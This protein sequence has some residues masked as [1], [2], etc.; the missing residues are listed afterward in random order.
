MNKLQKA[1]DKLGVVLET[2]INDYMLTPTE[3]NKIK[4]QYKTIQ[5]L[6]NQQSNSTFKEC[7]KEWEEKGYEVW[8]HNKENVIEFDKYDKSNGHLFFLGKIEI[9]LDDKEYWSDLCFNLEE[10]Q[11]LTK[12]LKALEVEDE[13]EN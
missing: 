1:F 8:H 2:I 12:T 13:K 9:D 7:I 3:I 4:K 5:E 10:C 11:L 6:I